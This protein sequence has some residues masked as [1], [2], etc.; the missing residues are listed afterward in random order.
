MILKIVIS[1]L[2][3]L[4]VANAV[5]GNMYIYKDKDGKTLIP[6]STP[7]RNYD[8]V[9]RKVTTLSRDK[10]GSIVTTTSKY[11]NSAYAALDSPSSNYSNN[12]VQRVITPIKNSKVVADASKH[13]LSEFEVPSGY[14]LPT[15]ADITGDWKRFD[16]PN[17]LK[18]DFNGDGIEDEAYILPKKGSR[19][20]YG[21]FVSMSKANKNI[22]AGHEF[23]MFKLTDSNDMSPQSFAIELAEPSNKI[24]KTA[25][26][27]GYWECGVDEPAE[28]KITK[29]SIMFCYIESA[30][31]LYL[32]GKDKSSFKEIQFSD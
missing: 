7:D 13:L 24:W 10:N 31:T 15:K 30:C 19:L 22:Q 21:V 4:S 9:S 5:A 14:R 12:S 8:K 32:S 17:H 23:Q 16:A 27:K 6:Q 20:G 25:C 29:P 2:L 26:G 11:A 1:S 18:A 3:A 28:I